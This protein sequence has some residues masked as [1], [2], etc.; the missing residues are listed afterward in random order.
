MCISNSEFFSYF[1]GPKSITFRV[2]KIWTEFLLVSWGTKT[3]KKDV[4]MFFFALDR[5]V[6]NQ[7][8]K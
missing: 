6:F 4:L 8:I 2:L 3:L 5:H 7:Y 1:T